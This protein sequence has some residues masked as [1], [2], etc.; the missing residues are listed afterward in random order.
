MISAFDLDG[1]GC[2]PVLSF[3]QIG[4]WTLTIHDLELNKLHV[5]PFILHRF[6]CK[7]AQLSLSHCRCFW[8]CLRFGHCLHFWLLPGESPAFWPISL[9]ACVLFL[10]GWLS[11]SG[12]SCILA[13][14]AFL[15]FAWGIACVCVRKLHL[16]FSTISQ[17]YLGL[18]RRGV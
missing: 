10:K 4:F 11:H 6:R 1:E 7:G 12:I 2:F 5:L 18:P 17:D 13:L 9:N 14:P 8:L 15:Y 3:I 16:M